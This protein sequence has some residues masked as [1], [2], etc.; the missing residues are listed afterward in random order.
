MT[1]N[2]DA[3]LPVEQIMAAGLKRISGLVE[4]HGITSPEVFS[5]CE[6]W[7]SILDDVNHPDTTCK[8]CGHP[9]TWIPSINAYIHTDANL[10][11]NLKDEQS[12]TWC[13]T[14]AGSQA[15]GTSLQD[16][17]IMS[18][19]PKARPLLKAPLS[20]RLSQPFGE[21]EVL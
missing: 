10:D 2:H 1:T 21:M 16:L 15:E 18:G 5:A 7:G 20:G 9:V 8:N 3:P 14:H 17:R 4:Q 6:R 19:S 11:P 12:A 13:K